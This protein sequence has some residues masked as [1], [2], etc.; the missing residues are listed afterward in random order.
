MKQ[1]K[2][3][4][5]RDATALQILRL[6]PGIARVAGVPGIS[7]AG[8]K[9]AAG[10]RSEAANVVVSPEGANLIYLVFDY[11]SYVQNNQK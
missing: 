4:G 6:A 11:L 7:A 10:I 8:I 5:I 1:E 2:R 9:S 3:T